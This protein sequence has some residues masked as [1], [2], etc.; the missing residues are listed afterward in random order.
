MI[1]AGKSRIRLV[2]YVRIVAYAG[3]VEWEHLSVSW[4][5]ASIEFDMVVCKGKVVVDGGVGYPD[6]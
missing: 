4:G 6:P 5:E 1:S 3:N 2:K